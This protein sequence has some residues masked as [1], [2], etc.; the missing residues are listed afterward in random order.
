MEYLPDLNTSVVYPK[1]I[2]HHWKTRFNFKLYNLER[3]LKNKLPNEF[4]NCLKCY[5]PY[6]HY[7]YEDARFCSYLDDHNNYLYFKGS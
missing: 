5:N 1:G 3:E 7:G 2:A 4:K 6:N